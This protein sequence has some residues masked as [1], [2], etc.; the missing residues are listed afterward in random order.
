[1]NY[2][3][4]ILINETNNIIEEKN[5]IKPKYNI[6][7]NFTK[8]NKQNNNKLLN[9]NFEKIKLNN[10]TMSQSFIQSNMNN[11][12]ENN[13]IL[14]DKIFIDDN[15]TD[16]K[17][18][19]IFTKIT[20]DYNKKTININKTNI[21]E[22]NVVETNVVE[23]NKDKI[24]TIET[25][26]IEMNKDKININNYKKIIDKKILYETFINKEK[27]IKE[28]FKKINHIEN[29]IDQYDMKFCNDDINNKD[30][31]E[32]SNTIDEYD[33]DWVS[34]YGS[35]IKEV[36]IFDK[37][38]KNKVDIIIDNNVIIKNI[39]NINI[40]NDDI[41]NIAILVEEYD[42]NKIN[43]NKIISEREIDL[44]IK[45]IHITIDNNINIKGDG[46]AIIDPAPCGL[47]FINMRKVIS[48]SNIT[49]ND[50]INKKS[51]LRLINK[52]RYNKFIIQYDE[53]IISDKNELNK[54]YFNKIKQKIF[55]EI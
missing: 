20:K 26:V 47:T 48:D 36:L 46:I 51:K 38:E 13:I 4:I 16:T 24:N 1:M 44:N 34:I 9:N 31:D 39:N 45:N 11:I 43:S 3:N 2:S 49:Y 5:E 30:I 14:K 6:N 23:M 27:N 21:V 54:K 12:K 40:L 7:F 28:T 37:I 50:L 55:S 35:N 22:T 19:K 18:N 52:I 41:E 17:T 32:I 10:M 29:I 53:L 42:N 8:I 33:V 15:N 25:N